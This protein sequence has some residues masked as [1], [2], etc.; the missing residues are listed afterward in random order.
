MKN[1]QHKFI[2]KAFI[3]AKIPKEVRMYYPNLIEIDTVIAGYCDILLRNKEKIY[4][5]PDKIITNNEKMIFSKL[6]NE[7]SEY[8]KDELIIYYR[9][10][11]LTE[12]ILYQYRK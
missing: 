3:E 1:K 10:M 9:L 11:I 2:L 8:S 6:I 7:S 4:I 5:L 12:F